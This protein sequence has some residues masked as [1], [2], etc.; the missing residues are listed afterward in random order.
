MP[1]H[2]NLVNIYHLCENKKH[3]HIQMIS[4]GSCFLAQ[5]FYWLLDSNGKNIE[6]E[7]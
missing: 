5:G 4:L 7:M 6:G 1:I 2:P 3:S